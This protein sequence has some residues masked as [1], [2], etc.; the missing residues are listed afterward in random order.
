MVSFLL[1][2]LP[3]ERGNWI[4]LIGVRSMYISWSVV[5]GGDGSE[6]EKNLTLNTN[7]EDRAPRP[8]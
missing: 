6:K 2:V 8:V 4:R 1:P 3:F 7:R 5:T